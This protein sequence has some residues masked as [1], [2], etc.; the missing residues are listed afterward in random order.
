MPKTNRAWTPCKKSAPLGI[1]LVEYYA[2]FLTSIT[3]SASRGVFLRDG[4]THVHS[5]AFC[6]ALGGRPRFVRVSVLPNVCPVHPVHLHPD[7]GSRGCFPPWPTPVPTLQFHLLVGFV[8][9]N[10]LFMKL[11][12][13]Y[14]SAKS[15]ISWK[16]L[17]ALVPRN[18]KTS[19]H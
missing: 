8:Y 5:S 3:K 19:T 10:T 16:L 9:V 13:Q 14:Q 6:P 4:N 15:V 11:Q 2:M 7:S 17:W 12:E 1:N 18:H